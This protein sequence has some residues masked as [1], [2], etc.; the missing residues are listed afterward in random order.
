MPDDFKGA[1]IYVSEACPKGTAYLVPKIDEPMWQGETYEQ[2]CRRV[3][4]MYPNRFA[5]I[6]GLG[7]A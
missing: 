7:D 4:A 2:W 5:V 1:R 3:V 6:R